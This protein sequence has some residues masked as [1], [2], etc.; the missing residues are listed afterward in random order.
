MGISST[1]E[2]TVLFLSHCRGA[3]LAVEPGSTGTVR[4]KGAEHPHS[5]LHPVL[6]DALFPSSHLGRTAIHKYMQH[7]R[8]RSHANALN[9][10]ETRLD[11]QTA[12][13][14]SSSLVPLGRIY[15]LTPPF[16]WR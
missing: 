3:W 16:L 13:Q 15:N 7:D 2:R 5:K 9:T 10:N 6:T 11:S 14:L 1:R 4:E 12:R 8:A